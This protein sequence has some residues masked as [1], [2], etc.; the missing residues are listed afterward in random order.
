MKT[1]TL[2]RIILGMFVAVVAVSMSVAQDTSQS[3]EV[4]SRDVSEET[5]EKVA[6]AYDAIE[7]LRAKYR[8]S[9]GDLAEAD[10]PEDVERQMIEEFMA[11]VEATGIS[12]NRYRSIL[13]AVRDDAVLHDRFVGYVGE[14]L[15]VTSAREDERDITRG[16]ANGNAR[17]ISSEEMVNVPVAS[18]EEM[19]GLMP[20]IESGLRIRGGSPSEVDFRVDGRSMRDGRTQAPFT[21]ISYTQIEE[22]HIETGGFNAEYGNARSGVISVKTKGGIDEPSLVRVSNETLDKIARAYVKVED[23]R[24]QYD[25]SD[26]ELQTSDKSNEQR[27]AEYKMGQA[28]VDE[29][30]AIDTYVEVLDAIDSNAALRKKL[31]ERVQRVQEG[32]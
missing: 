18:A 6:E 27:L 19:I 7:D 15:V 24:N 8:E 9:Y 29:G 20:G 30:V 4:R 5:L 14:E 28:I 32:G 17:D 12:W 2:S 16:V 11:A 10:L 22:I 21:G 25:L 23:I 26:E 31:L 13:T 1:Q 3:E